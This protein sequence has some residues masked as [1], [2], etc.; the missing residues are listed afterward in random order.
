MTVQ[1]KITGGIVAVVGY[2]LS[3][4]SWWNDTFVN[5]P[6]ALALAWVVSLFFSAGWREAYFQV[7]IV[8]GY[9][10]TNIIGL[11]LLQKGAKQ[12][13][14]DERKPYTRRAF[15]IDVGISLAYTGIILLLVKFGV[16][17]PIADY[18][19]GN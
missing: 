17:K 9:W 8:V 4:L 19:S 11:V 14:S 15:L 10:L 13:V 5:L 16:L 12:V 1:R 7:C 18:F 2:M 6:L 3:P